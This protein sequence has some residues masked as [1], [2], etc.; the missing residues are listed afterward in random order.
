[1]NLI[2]YNKVKGPAVGT[3]GRGN[4]GKI[5]RR[6]GKAKGGRHLCAA[7]K[8]HD[9]DAACGQLRL[10]TERELEFNLEVAFG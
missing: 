3:T 10:K 7:K 9:I 5:S 8:G 6:A 2:P 4:P 1:V